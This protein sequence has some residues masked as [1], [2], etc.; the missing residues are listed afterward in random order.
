[1]R[2]PPL[3]VNG[4][5]EILGVPLVLACWQ[6]FPHVLRIHDALLTAIEVSIVAE[7]RRVRLVS[8]VAA[9]PRK[10]RKQAPLITC[11]HIGVDET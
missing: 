6:G 11:A 4:I 8:R 9:R 7:P 1:M 10:K 5:L 3:V 2:G